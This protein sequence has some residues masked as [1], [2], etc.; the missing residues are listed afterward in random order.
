MAPRHFRLIDKQ[1]P[2]V[3][4]WLPALPQVQRF[5]FAFAMLRENRLRFPRQKI[6]SS[7]R[8]E[9]AEM[10]GM[11][12]NQASFTHLFKAV[13]TGSFFLVVGETFM[14]SMRDRDTDAGLNWDCDCRLAA[15]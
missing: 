4:F 8:E 13:F 5:S 7:P 9:P 10:T 2:Q 12:E 11:S 14:N 3:E 1:Q 15:Q 6:P